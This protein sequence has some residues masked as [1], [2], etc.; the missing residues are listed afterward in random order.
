MIDLAVKD[1]VKRARLDLAGWEEKDG[2]IFITVTSAKPI[3]ERVTRYIDRSRRLRECRRS[4]TSRPT[5]S[6]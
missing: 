1:A 5:A 4:R 6:G 2:K 3:D